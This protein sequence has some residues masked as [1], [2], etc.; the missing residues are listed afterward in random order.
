M[1]DLMHCEVND[2]VGVL[3]FSRPDR[4]NPYSV[5]FVRQLCAMLNQA[6]EDEAIRALVMTGGPH[7]S[8]GGDLVEFGR[9]VREGSRAT[10]AML[11][12]VH[13]G[14]RAAHGFNKPLISAVNGVCFGAGMPRAPRRYRCR[15]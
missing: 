12:L 15:R 14:A 9:I 11:D 2:G 6:A 8:S 5:D 10:Q 1:T 4:R 13:S 7:F 3:R